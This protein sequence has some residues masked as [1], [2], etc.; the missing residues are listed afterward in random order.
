M[1]LRNKKGISPLIATVLLIV[2]AV[3]LVAIVLN[4]GKSFTT[5]SLSETGNIIDTTCT[6]ASLT[7]PSCSVIDG[8]IVFYVKNIGSNYDFTT[9]DDFL[10][11]VSS[12]GG[13]Y[14][15]SNTI[16]SYSTWA[17]LTSG[18]QVKVNMDI[19]DLGLTGDT[20]NV[21]VKSSVC[22]S[23]ATYTF[24]NCHS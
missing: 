13:D 22:S 12:D 5:N 19:S 3:A 10:I 17:G 7:I 21:T 2:V 6:G 9:A 15:G 20:F 24:K 14:N 16:S 18:Q 8:N 4:W 23:D 1:N 11:Q